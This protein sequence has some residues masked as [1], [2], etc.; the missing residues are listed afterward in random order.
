MQRHLIP[1]WIFSSASWLLL[2]V[3]VAALGVVAKHAYQSNFSPKSV[4]RFAFGSAFLNKSEVRADLS[5]VTQQH[6]FG[7]VPPVKKPVVEKPKVVEAP[8]TRL[9]LSLTGVIT[10][11]PV[12]QS[13]AMVEIKRGQTSVVRIGDPI[14]KT[15][16][17]LNEVHSDH[18]IIE[19]RGKPERLELVRP[20]MSLSDLRSQNNQTIDAL[21]INVA[22]FE[23]LAKVNPTD[24]DITK[25][26]PPPAPVPSNTS[27]VDQEATASESGQAVTDSEI[28]QLT[29][30]QMQELEDLDRLEEI[31]ELQRILDEGG[32]DQSEMDELR[33]ELLLLQSEQQ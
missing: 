30:R 25:L 29:L 4:Q 20:K 14:G 8:K 19:Y 16:A 18:I 9:K 31:R 1:N 10:S 11:D 28:Q 23:A 33:N 2:F 26:L 6:I 12:S 13:L 5:E 17:K 32:L 7:V 22:E 27:E 15:G 3:G 24:L 21:N